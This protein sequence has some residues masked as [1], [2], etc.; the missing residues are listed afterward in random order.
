MSK[1]LPVILGP[2]AVGKTSLGIRLA[3][4]LNGE[5]VSADSRQVYIGMEIGN[6]A[7]TAVEM[8]NIPHHFISCIMPHQRLSSGKYASLARE[9]IDEIYSRDKMPI[10]VGGSGLYIRALIEGLS[11]IPQPDLALRAQILAEV[12]LRGMADM[13]KELKNVDP[14]YAESIE[15][16]NK[17]RLIR[18]LEVYRQ[19]GRTFSDWHSEEVS[20]PPFEPVLIG[21]NMPR[22]LLH[23]V[24]HRRVIGMIE[25]GW[26]QEVEK[27]AEQYGGYERLP[28]TVMEGIGYRE[29]T[30]LN[31]EEIE[32]N[33]AVELIAIRTRQF[34]KRQMTWFGRDKRIHWITINDNFGIESAVEDS[35]RVLSNELLTM[36]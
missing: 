8:G 17:K 14:E 35:M 20:P 21:L 28:V 19:T 9:C 4:N 29:M 10:V 33:T 36:T 25:S 15:L 11:P 13:I 22:N 30:R 32:L 27:L 7:P 34:A 2:T 16:N 24:I 26:R 5:I 31:N 3:E 6:G 18:A 1:L 23:D 12:E